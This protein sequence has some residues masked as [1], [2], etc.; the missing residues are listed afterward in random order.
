MGK[1][2]YKKI[3][4][5]TLCNF[6]HRSSS[7]PNTQ[8]I[9]KLATDDLWFLRYCRSMVFTFVFFMQKLTVISSGQNNKS[10]GTFHHKSNKIGLTF[11]WFFCDFLSNLQESGNH[12]NYWSSPFA[13]RTLARFLCL[14]CSPWGRWPAWVGQFRRARRRSLPGKGRGRSYG[15]LGVDSQW[16]WG[17]AVPARV[18]N[19]GGRRPALRAWFWRDRHVAE[20]RRGKVS[21]RGG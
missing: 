15:A 2:F 4:I 18:L 7:W 14:Q 13:K 6:W 5:I 19:S 9:Q 3:Y 12:F 10:C 20:A 1:H 8:H 17:A 16:I 11:F 21:Y